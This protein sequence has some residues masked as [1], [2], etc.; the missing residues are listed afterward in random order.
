[1]NFRNIHYFKNLNINKI[2]N[3]Y[4]S[5]FVG[6]LLLTR[7]VIFMHITGD[8]FNT[9][10]SSVF[11]IIG[12]ILALYKIVKDFKFFQNKFI[13]ALAIFFIIACISTILNIE[14]GL[15]SNLKMLIWVF[16]HFFLL[17]SLTN[18]SK[19]E[20]KN[21][22]YT[23]GFVIVFIMFICSFI[24]I[25]QF[26][27]NITF[28]INLP[29]YPRVQGFYN[30][31]LFGVFD[32]PN[33]ASIAS[34]SSLAFSLLFAKNTV[35]KKNKIFFIF[36][37][38]IQVSYIILSNSRTGL[39][40]LIICS[41]IFAYYKSSQLIINKKNKLIRRIVSFFM[42]FFIL[43]TGLFCLR[44]FYAYCPNI[45]HKEEVVVENNA[46]DDSKNTI[47]N[48]SE[49]SKEQNTNQT[50]E[51]NTL[52]EIDVQESKE[53]NTNQSIENN[54]LEEK[55]IQES[56]DQNTNQSIENNALKREDIVADFSNN[57]FD[58]WHGALEVSKDKRVFGVSPRNLIPYAK[59]NFPYSYTAQTG[60]ETHNGYLSV[61]VSTGYLGT[62]SLA[63]FILL[64]ISDLIKKIN[65]KMISQHNIVYYMIIGT[66]A[67]STIMLQDV[68]FMNTA[69][70]VIFWRVL[71]LNTFGKN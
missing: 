65:K 27:F 71:G 61:F 13:I 39:V 41:I 38:F 51:D 48:T 49:E 16:I 63:F 57:R 37:M 10:I 59:A 32:D 36:N 50:I 46:V 40:G 30:G 69:T 31:R 70:T 67:F 21:A 52:E 60:Y 19:D 26:F 17:F 34:I 43:F 25:L 33:Y 42:T 7:V 6:Y 15:F 3:Y 53:Q 18:Y 35:N 4:I 66:M 28:T 9:F 64:C 14:Y 12:V 2:I 20:Y 68:F 24:S 58:I 55:D 62:I 54:A 47:D 8:I 23:L 1:M 29:D 11:A 5:F 56:K 45:L 44:E 22:F